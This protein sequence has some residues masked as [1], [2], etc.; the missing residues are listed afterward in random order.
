MESLKKK[1]LGKGKT[2]NFEKHCTKYKNKD[3][4][5]QVR[6]QTK[7]GESTHMALC[8]EGSDLKLAA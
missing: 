4:Q 6:A 2:M 7:G 8:T 3:G 1:K 5:D